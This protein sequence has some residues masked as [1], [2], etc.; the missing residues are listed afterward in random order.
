MAVNLA[1][2]Y[3]VQGVV[4]TLPNY[5]LDTNSYYVLALD[6]VKF[7]N[8][9]GVNAHQWISGGLS[10]GGEDII[11]VMP[12]GDTVDIVDYDD[13]GVWPSEPDGNGPSLTFCNPNL[14]N[15]NGANWSY[16]TTFVGV[17]AAGDSIWANPGTGCGNIVPPP[18]GDTIPPVVNNTMIASGTSVEVYFSEPVGVSAETTANYTGLGT[19][20]TAVR[21]TNGDMVTLTLATALVDGVNNTLT[22]DNVK[23]TSGNVMAVAQSFDLIFNGSNA[24]LLITEIMYNDPSASDSLEYFEIYNNG[25]STANIGGMEVT[26]GVSFVFPANTSLNAGDYLVIAKDAALV[27]A[28][29]GVSGTL[30]WTS[31]GLKNSGEDIAIQNSLGDTMAYVDYDDASPWP[32]AA[33][34]DGPS[35]EFCDKSLD[36][37]DGANWSLSEKF[38]VV[39]NGDSIFGTP[40]ADCYH[41][42]INLPN[43]NSF[44]SIYPNPATSV[45]YITT[46]NSTFDMSIFDV[47]GR[48]VMQQELKGSNNT[49]NIKS[50]RSGMYYIQFINT[51]TATR[52]T[53]KLIVE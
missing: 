41:D 46:D 21:N 47:S 25:A 6:S 30:Q 38:A 32:V 2:Y 44:V 19:V 5:I 52:F 3:F 51:K 27:D 36:N 26:Q 14:D 10:N 37:N 49:V 45:L 15:N 50:L 7:L 53:K 22:I 48:V 20:S 23:D 8:F 40:G 4:D 28:V 16:A 9:F 1:G 29:F 12:S 11:L 18:T 35:L 33:D 42:A 24:D 39:F 13:G 34:G 43:S 31:G 17:N